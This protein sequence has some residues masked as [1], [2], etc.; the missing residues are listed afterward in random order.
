MKEKQAEIL[1]ITVEVHKEIMSIS[2]N[3]INYCILLYFI[4]VLNSQSLFMH[5]RC[6]SGQPFRVLGQPLLLSGQ[7]KS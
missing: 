3:P 6:V 5:K 1:V 7:L 2:H 4:R